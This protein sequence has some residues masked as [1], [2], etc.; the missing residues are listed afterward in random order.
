MTD[1]L[2]FAAFLVL[3]LFGLWTWRLEVVQR[4]HFTGRVAVAGAAG[5]V[6][7]AVV[8]AVFSLL[9]VPWWV[10]L[11]AGIQLPLLY[12]APVRRRERFNP[13][14]LGFLALTVYGILTARESAGDSS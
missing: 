10:V 5:A 4:M 1:V 6:T 7:T 14:I 3:P 13:Y 2:F 11:I 12:F 8:M 9:R